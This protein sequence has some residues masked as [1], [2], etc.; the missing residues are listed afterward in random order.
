MHR[1]KM[2]SFRLKTCVIMP[3]YG[4]GKYYMKEGEVYMIAGLIGVVIVIIIASQWDKLQSTKNIKG[5]MTL[6]EID[7]LIQKTN[8]ER[9]I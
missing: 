6:K 2:Y 4:I 9:S 1:Y 3:I 8:D 5:K 7:D